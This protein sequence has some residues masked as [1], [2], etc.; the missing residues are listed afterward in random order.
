MYA[1]TELDWQTPHTKSAV[2]LLAEIGL[3]GKVLVVLKQQDQVQVRSFRNLPTVRIVQARYVTAYDVLWARDLLF[4]DGTLPI[5]S[6]V[7]NDP[8]QVAAKAS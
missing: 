2:K 7:G 3:G 5:I 8:V 4:C 6:G 1:L